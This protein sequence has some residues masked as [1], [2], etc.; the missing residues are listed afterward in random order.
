[1]K[2]NNTNDVPEFV[3]TN[4][5]ARKANAGTK[6]TLFTSSDVGINRDIT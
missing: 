3:L 5:K 4:S 6:I 2:E 1:M